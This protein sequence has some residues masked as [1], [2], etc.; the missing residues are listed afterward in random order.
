MVEGARYPFTNSHGRTYASFFQLRWY[1][2]SGMTAA[3]REDI[4]FPG[5][6]LCLAKEFGLLFDI[7]NWNGKKE[8]W[9]P[10]DPNGRTMWSGLKFNNTLFKALIQSS[11]AVFSNEKERTNFLLT[12]EYC[13]YI[14]DK[15]IEWYCN[16]FQ[17]CSYLSN[18]STCV[19][20]PTERLP[21]HL[22]FTLRHSMAIITC[23]AI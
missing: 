16:R 23:L 13:K 20:R 4:A 21:L 17:G 9:I 7:P 10:K 18:W 15:C 12:V 19:I 1:C 8:Y 14:W 11:K 3:W 22:K 5:Y 6:V 2:Y